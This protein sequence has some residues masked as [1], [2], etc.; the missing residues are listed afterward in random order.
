MASAAPRPDKPAYAGSVA[1]RR[2]KEAADLFKLDVAGVE[3]LPDGT[4]RVMEA[5]AM[6]SK[7]EDLFD[8]L[9]REGKL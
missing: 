1:I 8:Q 5:R 9:D 4:I 7:E 3:L 2:A 6:P